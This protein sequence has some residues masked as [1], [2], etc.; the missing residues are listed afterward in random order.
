MKPFVVC[1]SQEER[2]EQLRSFAFLSGIMA[3]FGMAALLQ[4]T[5]DP[6]TVN[7]ALQIGFAITVAL[8][9]CIWLCFASGYV[10]DCLLAVVNSD[11]WSVE[12]TE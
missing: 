2:S 12:D 6:D 4:L 11:S 7:R 3:G 10:S 1:S 8:T 5:F 9:V